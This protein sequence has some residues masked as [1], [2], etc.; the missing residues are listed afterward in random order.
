[1]VYADSRPAAEKLESGRAYLK[2]LDQKIIRLR[3]DGKTA[4]VEKMKAEKKT[5]IDRMKVWKAEAESAPA[6]MAPTPPSAPVAMAPAPAAGA[7]LLGL[8]LN[9]G[10]TVGYTMA[11]SNSLITG[12]GDVILA[13]A[14]G[15]GPML[16]L[17]DDAI[18]WKIG[19]GGATGNDNNGTSMKAI[20]LFVD[21]IIALPADLL[22]GIESY[23]GGGV[24]YVLY[25]SGTTSGSYGGQV[26]YGIAG[27]IGLGGSSY[28]ELGYS[29]IRSGTVGSYSAKGI[30]I[31]VGT[32]LLL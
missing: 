23:V 31:N 22:G 19:L 25:G 3:K 4:L 20:P 16:G 12:R 11:G 17:T 7:G 10:Y 14:M 32:E 13:D 27:D 8:G 18:S 5:T 30:G 15:I 1:M 28:A 2:L 24:N 6:P 21:G 26:C 29:I 9:T